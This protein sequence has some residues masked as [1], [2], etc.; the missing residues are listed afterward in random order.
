MKYG[1]VILPDGKVPKI[2]VLVLSLQNY[3]LLQRKFLGVPQ[4]KKTY[5][6]LN[7]TFFYFF[8]AFCHIEFEDRSLQK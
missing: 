7:I 4:T 2:T 6:T 3:S 5:T 1:I 8:F